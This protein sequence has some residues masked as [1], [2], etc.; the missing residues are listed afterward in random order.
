L[1]RPIF[2]ALTTR[3]ILLE[4]ED[5]MKKEFGLALAIAFGAIFVGCGQ[6]PSEPNNSTTVMQESSAL[7]D[8]GVDDA[9]EVADTLGF[10]DSSSF[11]FSSSALSLA[12]SPCRSIVAGSLTDS[13]LDKIPDDVTFGFNEAN[14]LRN[15]PGAGGTITRGGSKRITDTSPN[16]ER[17]HSETLTNLKTIWTRSIEGKNVV[18]TAT[19][20]GT[21]N[22]T[23]G[24]A[25]TLTRVHDVVGSSVRSVD[26]VDGL[27]ISWTNQLTV[28]Y[29]A[30][31]AGTISNNAPLPDGTVSI[32]GTWKAKRGL[33]PERNFT[34]SS[35]G[36]VFS[37][38]ATCNKRR[39]TAGTLSFED[40]K[41]TI[42]V[43]FNGC[44]T[45]P[46]VVVTPKP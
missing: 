30:S 25:T 11:G 1:E 26:A 15:L 42:A 36:L 35:S 33:R 18:W 46:S 10:N 37:S 9:E 38:S 45:A 19:R 40:S 3:A 20:N 21:R 23:Q 4:K 14:C 31:G 39:L 44:D 32:S 2:Y 34:V 22:V 17:N 7:G 43:T 12:A 13:D 8:Q 28:A 27:G 16:S 5:N 41:S 29:T 24:S 6:T